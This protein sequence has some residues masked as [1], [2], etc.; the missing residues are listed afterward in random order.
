MVGT[1]FLLMYTRLIRIFPELPS[2]PLCYLRQ[3][4]TNPFLNA[5]RASHPGHTFTTAVFD[6]ERRKK[7]PLTGRRS[8]SLRWF[9][10]DPVAQDPIHALDAFSVFSSLLCSLWR[11]TLP[12]CE[13]QAEQYALRR[14]SCKT[15]DNIH[16][17]LTRSRTYLLTTNQ[18]TSLGPFNHPASFRGLGKAFLAT[19]IYYTSS[20]FSAE[21]FIMVWVYKK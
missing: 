13:Q 4:T 11:P 10:A 3:L 8:A 14:H 15:L 12:L 2:Q 18:F 17:I 5:K 6:T 16:R 9:L 19:A 21:A 7:R 20:F 1:G